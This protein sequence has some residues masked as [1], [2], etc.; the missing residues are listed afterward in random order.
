MAIASHL[1]DASPKDDFPTR[2]GHNR[3][4][5]LASSAAA[6]RGTSRSRRSRGGLLLIGIIA[7]LGLTV[8][9]VTLLV[10]L[11]A[12]TSAPGAQEIKVAGTQAVTLPVAT[13]PALAP[14]AAPTPNAAVQPTSAPA[15]PEPITA[16]VR[17]PLLDARFVARVAPGWLDNPPFAT[18]TDG[19]YRLQARQAARFVAVG[20]PIDQ[21][22]SD[23]IV[24]ATFRKTGGPPGGGYGLVL[25]DQGPVPRDGANQTMSAYVFEAGDVGEFGIWRRDGGHWVDLVSWS[26]SAIVRPGGSPNDLA[27]RAVGKR[28]TFTINGTQV[29]SIDDGVLTAGGVGVFVG[30]DFNEVAL[31]HFTVEQPN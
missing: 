20:A 23:V 25:R 18:W 13:P 21:P 30:G 9:G 16:P 17:Q 10:I 19:A 1:V 14:T 28:F 3:S 29:A 2:F 11:P 5:S 12:L 27:V 22:P 4:L 6:P 26:P 24:S 7:V 8:L 15:T 31:D